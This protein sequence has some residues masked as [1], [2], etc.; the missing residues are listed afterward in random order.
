MLVRGAGN[1]LGTITR[2][3]RRWNRSSWV[4]GTGMFPQLPHYHRPHIADT[5]MLIEDMRIIQTLGRTPCTRNM[6]GSLCETVLQVMM[7]KGYWCLDAPT[8]LKILILP[9]RGSMFFTDGFLLLFFEYGFHWFL[10][11]SLIFDTWSTPETSHLSLGA[12]P[13]RSSLT[14][15]QKQIE[16]FT[17]FII[18]NDVFMQKAHDIWH[19]KL[20]II[21]YI[22]SASQKS[23]AQWLIRLWPSKFCK[24][25]RLSCRSCQQQGAPEPIY[26]LLTNYN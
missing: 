1:A 10:G 14:C 19:A 13:F 20:S 3:L 17:N 2:Q 26:M 12:C 23:K 24:E 25:M 7:L 5:N 18:L 4:C 6:Y 11:S 8:D 21:E 22:S 16:R 15:H 9:S